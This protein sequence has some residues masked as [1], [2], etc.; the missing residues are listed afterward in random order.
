M[1]RAESG[2]DYNQFQHWLAN[3]M[4]LA[5]MRYRRQAMTD[6]D[7][8]HLF[9]GKAF[10]FDLRTVVAAEDLSS[11]GALN[12]TQDF[13]DLVP[14]WPDRINS[15][16]DFLEYVGQLES[17]TE[18]MAKGVPIEEDDRKLLE[19]FLEIYRSC[20]SKRLPIGNPL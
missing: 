15:K 13:F 4:L 3:N 2:T 20:Q 9:R 19:Q 16:D 7:K 5:S 8:R 1:C 18:Q 10:F 17:I 6:E 14:H 12:L 11:Q